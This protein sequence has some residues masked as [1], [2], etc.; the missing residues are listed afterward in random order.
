MKRSILTA[1]TLTLVLA[2]VLTACGG[3]SKPTQEDGA[4]DTE[5]YVAQDAAT[6]GEADSPQPESSPVQREP[7]DGEAAQAQPGEEQSEPEGSEEPEQAPEPSYEELYAP[8][9]EAYEGIISAQDS[10]DIY[11]IWDALDIE[12][13]MPGED[14]EYIRTCHLFETWLSRDYDDAAFFKGDDNQPNYYFKDIDGDGVTELFIGN[15]APVGRSD[16]TAVY[17]VLGG[18]VTAVAMGWSRSMYHE[19]SDGCIYYNG[20]GGAMYSTQ[21]RYEFSGGKLTL[22]EHLELN[23]DYDPPYFYTVSPDGV[24]TPDD[25]ITEEEYDAISARFEEQIMR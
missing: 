19:G 23:G 2:V 14:L 12:Y 25:A 4:S 18:K 17:T 1:L 16:V 3:A 9:L 11:G 15:I 20:S 5:P 7:E 10:D 6:G 24:I 21:E 8:V 13:A 22:A